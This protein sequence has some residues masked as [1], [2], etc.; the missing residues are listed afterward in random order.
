MKKLKFKVQLEEKILPD[1]S[2][3]V[4]V[5]EPKFYIPKGNIFPYGYM[6]VDNRSFFNSF[7]LLS[8]YFADWFD[9]VGKSNISAKF[10]YKTVA[11][12]K[13]LSGEKILLYIDELQKKNGYFPFA[14]KQKYMGEK[15]DFES[16]ESY[17]QDMNDFKKL[18]EAIDQL[19]I[20]QD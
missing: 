13:L 15:K 6:I 1:S 16:C 11:K 5:V 12:S 20:T 3:I 10:F 9:I 4:A 7:D 2:K 19:E 8:T 14:G 18:L 17:Q